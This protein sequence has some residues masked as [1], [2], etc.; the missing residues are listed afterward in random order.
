MT[1]YHETSQAMQG[2][3]GARTGRL[4]S[5]VVAEG[6]AEISVPAG[7][8]PSP[9]VE[10]NGLARS[11]RLAA[12]RDLLQED[13]VEVVR[14]TLEADPSRTDVMYVLARLLQDT[15]QV[16]RAE[17][18][19][20][21]IVALEPHP[22]VCCDLARLCASDWRRCGEGLSYAQKAVD[23]DPADAEASL[24][25]GEAMLRF[26]RTEEG[27][28]M[29]ERALALAPEASEIWLRWLWNL[30][31]LPGKDRAFFFSQYRRWGQR[32]A[33]LPGPCRP[34]VANPDVRRR[35]RVGLI[36]GEFQ[37]NS[38]ASPWEPFLELCDR[39]QFEVYGYGYPETP[40]EGTRRFQSRFDCY[41]DI[42]GTPWVQV[43]EQIREDR[44]DILVEN[45]GHCTRNPLPVFVYQPA[46]VQVDCGGID[47]LGLP[48][49]G[50]RFT[51]RI[52][53]PPETHRFY[54]ERSVFLPG[55][56]AFFVPPLESPPVTPLP[57][58]Q[59][60]AV[61]FGAFNNL[62]KVNG[63]VRSLW[64]QVLLSVPGSRLVVK[65]P[66]ASDPAVQEFIKAEFE[67]LGVECDRV[68]LYGSVSR[69]RH[70][71]LL[72]QVDLLL[73]TFPYNG[74]RTTMEGLWMGVPTLSLTGGLYVSRVGLD[75]L[76]RVHLEA[77]AAGS[78][79]EYVAKAAA[80]AGQWD[81][82]E[83]IRGS[84]RRLMLRSDL[85]DPRRWTRDIEAALR[86]I[87]ADACEGRG[88]GDHGHR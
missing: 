47:T 35:L 51:D 32:H 58:K 49:I 73:D 9:L 21:K 61:T 4:S 40:D 5:L 84:L 57:A 56:Q 87:W 66:T 38:P 28:G 76:S 67:R 22:R 3:A 82:L 81:C 44:V 77:F 31:Y 12:A 70:L 83:S 11:G 10:A 78:P 14:Q 33:T 2:R 45:G 25:C 27:V 17:P 86:A 71:Q 30:H 1:A 36:C 37:E 42:R 68:T 64:A 43:A 65:F 55:G 23:A 88:Q 34:G 80:F 39:G 41:R 24:L 85:C 15:G 18:W 54:G 19:L 60:K 75:V 53:D 46:P 8:L 6:G 48:Q 52:L 7:L 29:F 59:Q 50:Y 69:V 79:S 13:R 20:K 62:A 16:G 26:G 74:C 63:S 72:G